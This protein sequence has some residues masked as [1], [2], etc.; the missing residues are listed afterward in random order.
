M[1][2][3]QSEILAMK[4]L[5]DLG[6]GI[7]R[8]TYE[9]QMQDAPR[10]TGEYAMVKCRSSL[11]P[12]YDETDLLEVNGVMTY[13]TKGVRILTFD[14][15]F[16]RVG[17]EYIKFDNCFGR[18][19]V[20]S[21]TEKNRIAVLDKKA[22]ELASVVLE[23]NWEFRQALRMSVNVLRIDDAPVGIMDNAN[24]GGIFVDGETTIKV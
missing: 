4:R 8:F 7:R 11:N 3:R 6:V 16:S 21:F 20:R 18:P 2:V 10:P 17:D 14:I 15:V 1:D 13:R 22:L 24:V 5:V 23:T 19:D 12:G 9:A